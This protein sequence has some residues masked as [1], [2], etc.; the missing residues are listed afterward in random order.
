[1]ACDQRCR[2]RIL[3]EDRVPLGELVSLDV[4]RSSTTPDQLDQLRNELLASAE[5]DPGVRKPELQ[6]DTFAA[7]IAVMSA[8]GGLPL[9]VADP[10][11][12]YAYLIRPE[13]IRS[14][15]CC[16][17]I[18][19]AACAGRFI[20][21]PTLMLHS[22]LEVQLDGQPIYVCGTDAKKALRLRP[23]SERRLKEIVN[24]II[25]RARAHDIVLTSAEVCAQVRE[26]PEVR[27][28]SS[29]QIARIA[30]ELKPEDWKK[31]GPRSR[32]H[33]S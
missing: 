21:K 9:Y 6:G 29:R 25:E 1:M 14:G 31:P 17:S 18:I 30:R 15:C 26:Y 7:C 33:R 19:E 32:A 13:V 8:R 4:L 16:W 3:L 28:V 11:R 2:R 10:S 27:G 12:T 23:T 5:P 20:T 24:K 22:S